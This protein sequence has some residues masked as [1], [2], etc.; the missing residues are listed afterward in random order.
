MSNNPAQASSTPAARQAPIVAVKESLIAIDVSGTP[1]SKNEVGHIVLGHERL[2]AEVLRI[3]GGRADMQVFEDTR[4]VK[5]GDPVE[6][7]GQMLSVSLGPGLLGQVF[8]GLQNPLSV[9]AER[10]GFFLPRGADVP[11]L[12]QQKKW[13]FTPAVAAGDRVAAGPSSARPGKG[14]SITR[15]WRPLTWPGRPR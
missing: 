13:P 5:V 12:D 10:H 1:V 15:S 4:G 9:L 2:M 7:S 3:E 6:L 8:D 14:P 11:P